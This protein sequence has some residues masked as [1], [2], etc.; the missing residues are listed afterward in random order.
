MCVIDTGNP[1]YD[2]V[3]SQMLDDSATHMKPAGVW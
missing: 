1:K 3:L 2:A